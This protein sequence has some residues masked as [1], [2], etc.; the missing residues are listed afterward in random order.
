MNSLGTEDAHKGDRSQRT[1]WN[2]MPCLINW[3]SQCYQH[4]S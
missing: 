3:V 2:F 1:R 4:V